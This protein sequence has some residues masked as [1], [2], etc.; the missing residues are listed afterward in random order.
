MIN[1]FS[2]S[3]AMITPGKISPSGP[4]GKRGLR[5]WGHKPRRKSTTTINA[6]SVRFG[7]LANRAPIFVLPHQFQLGDSYYGAE[8]N[9]PGK[10]GGSGSKLEERWTSVGVVDGLN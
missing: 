3:C 8:F 4:K 9:T 6:G 10:G 2:V 5:F 1:D 7:F